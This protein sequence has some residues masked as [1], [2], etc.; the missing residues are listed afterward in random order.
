[1]ELSMTLVTVSFSV[2]ENGPQ[3]SANE[4]RGPFD[5]ANE[6]SA[7]RDSSTGY[8]RGGKRHK[9]RGTGGYFEMDYRWLKK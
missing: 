8:H 2:D 7:T 6:A 5:A 4:E 9:R 1:M 3:L